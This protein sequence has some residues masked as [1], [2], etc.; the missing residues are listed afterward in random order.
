MN[1]SAGAANAA[2]VGRR[3]PFIAALVLFALL[4]SGGA[5]SLAGLARGTEWL[6]H[7]AAV[8]FSIERLR[9]SLREAETGTGYYVVT[10]DAAFLAPYATTLSK[11][12]SQLQ[13]VRN[14][15]SDSPAQQKRMAQVEQ[16]AAEGLRALGERTSAYDTGRRGTELVATLL[17]GK[18]LM[19]DTRR[20]LNAIEME[21][22]RLDLVRQDEALSRW[23]SAVF[24]FIGG[25]FALLFALGAVWTE[26]KVTSAQRRRADELTR[27]HELLRIVI[28]GIDIGI[29]VQAKTGQL[30]YANSTAAQVIGYESPEALLEAPLSSIMGRFEVFDQTGSAFPIANLPSRAALQ[31]RASDEIM[32]RFR[33]RGTRHER[34]SLV[35]SIR[36]GFRRVG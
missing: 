22:A 14:L 5:Y 19:D 31:G 9:F 23:R 33:V 21:E 24:L 10:G 25:A 12:R 26:R 16:L 2:T 11:W 34:W 20:M 3:W 4:L 28:Q 7:A 6:R 1:G 29:T 30:V 8:R 17:R 35:R 15:T 27:A 36:S 13:Q 18:Q 32:L